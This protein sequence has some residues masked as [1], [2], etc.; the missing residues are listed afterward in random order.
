MLWINA[1]GSISKL[2]VQCSCV[3]NCRCLIHQLYGPR[4][5]SFGHRG[6]SY[7]PRGVSY[8]PGCIS[9]GLRGI[10][11]G[12][13]GISYEP[14]GI[15]YGLR[16][17]SYGCSGISYGPRGISYE[18]RGSAMTLGASAMGLGASAMHQITDPLLLSSCMVCY[19]G[20]ISFCVSVCLLSNDFLLDLR[21]MIQADVSYISAT[22]V[23]K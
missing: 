7:G 1:V 9:F 2:Y 12:P 13:R 10:S 21:E 6:I 14:R 19:R 11:Y 17:I 5:I 3:E 16:D 15:S 8:G 23:S 20:L 22:E 4:G 18:P